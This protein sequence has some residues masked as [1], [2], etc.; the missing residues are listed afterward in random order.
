MAIDTIKLKSP[1]M[2]E[3]LFLAIETTCG[4]LRQG[5]RLSTG[6]ILYQITIGELEGSWDSR[7]N[8]R[9]MRDDWRRGRSGRPELC[10]SEPYI[11]VECSLAKVF[12]G[13]NIYGEP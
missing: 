2:D 7:I 10:P 4:L 12:N 13:Q 5:V 9:P 3:Y 1:Y 8:I 6:E 11:V